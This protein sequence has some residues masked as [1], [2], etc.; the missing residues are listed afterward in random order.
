MLFLYLL[1]DI[2]RHVCRHLRDDNVSL[3]CFLALN[4][5]KLIVKDEAVKTHSYVGSQVVIINGLVC[6]GIPVGSHSAH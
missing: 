6:V 2:D 1:G 4:G 5:V 3:I